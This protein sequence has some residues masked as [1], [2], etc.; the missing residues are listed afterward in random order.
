MATPISPSK[1]S[2]GLA[3]NAFNAKSITQDYADVVIEPE[4][5][6]KES[7]NEWLFNHHI[8]QAIGD[9]GRI[10]NEELRKKL[11]KQEKARK[12]SWKE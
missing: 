2:R 11:F 5:L 12:E 7:K 10:V 6:Q 9:R 3:V 1:K 4:S 8:F